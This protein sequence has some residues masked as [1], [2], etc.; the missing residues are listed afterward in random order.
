MHQSNRFVRNFAT[1][2]AGSLGAAALALSLAG[3]GGAPREQHMQWVA[4]DAWDPTCAEKAMVETWKAE[5]PR[6]KIKGEVYVVDVEAKFRLSDDCK[7][8]LPLLGKSYKSLEV[9]TYKS[10]GL[11]MSRCKKDG[12]VGWALP[13]NESSRCWT[14]P[15]LLKQ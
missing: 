2:L 4:R 6:W 9:A 7:S 11:E 15:T 14:G 10:Q 1:R 5:N 12:A 13:G 3:C 8:G